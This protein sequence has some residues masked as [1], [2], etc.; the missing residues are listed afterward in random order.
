[1][2]VRREGHRRRVL[3]VEDEGADRMAVQRALRGW[4]ERYALVEATTGE[5][6][7]A[8]CSGPEAPDCVLLDFHLPDMTALE[9]MQRLDRGGRWALPLP[10]VVLTAQEDDAAAA[11]TLG[12]GAEDYL[13][14]EFVERRALARA[15]ENA[16]ERHRIRREL[17]EQRTVVEQRNRKLEGLRDELQAKVHELADATRAKDRF[18]AVMSHEMR[19]PLNA[20]LGYSDLLDLEMDGPLSDG[21][22]AHLQRIRVGSRHLLDLI[23][24]VLDLTRADVRKLELD[25]RPV[26]VVAVIEEVVALLGSEAASS[27]IALEFEPP[28]GTLPLVQADLQRLRQIVTNL[29][30]NAVKFTDEGAVA[31]SVAAPDDTE[32]I[33]RV[34]DTG[35]GIDPESLPLVFEEFYQA[36]GEL[37]RRH[38]GSGLGLAISRQLAELMGGEITVESRVGEGSV[39]TLRLPRAHP[40]APERIADAAAHREWRES[41]EPV[42]VDPIC[43]VALGGDAESLRELEQRVAPTVRLAWT[44]EPARLT[45]LVLARHPALVMIDISAD[46]G[47]A[48]NA[49][50]ALQEHPELRD[51]A[52]LLLPATPV[53]HTGGDKV[54][55][56]DLGWVSL[57]PKPFTASQLTA[58]LSRARGRPLGGDTTDKVCRVLVVDDDEDSRR[59]ASKFLEEHHVQVVEAGDGESAL[60]AMRDS[61]PDIVVLDLMMPVLDGFGVLAAMRADPLLRGVPVVVLTAKTLTEAERQFLSRTA[62]RVLQKGQHRLADVAALVLRAATQ[63]GAGQLA[64]QNRQ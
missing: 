11:A 23:N 27:G 45:E 61:P 62:A 9:F 38:G 21:Q 20:I 33:V 50:F 3:L 34:A 44:T 17:E 24:T 16:I 42:A 8:R 6:G 12:A 15:I 53:A 60:D 47:A 4:G 7:L 63:A 35:I 1:M 48:W 43:V 49:A 54:T 30:G 31:V 46:G 52:V 19:T 58:A 40:E 51:T 10:I 22:R 29:V 55:G 26:D 28:P 13:G 56:L 18:L 64:G 59:V 39:F 25:M 57:V 2:T 41:R 5:E 36:Q 14:K 32:V 37:T